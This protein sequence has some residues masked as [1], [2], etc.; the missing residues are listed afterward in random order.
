MVIAALVLVLG[1]GGTLH[2][3]CTLADIS[4]EE[5]EKRGVALASD[6]TAE[7]TELL[8]T[9]DIFSLYER[10]SRLV[11]S[12]SDVR[13]IVVLGPEGQVRASTFERGLPR[14]LREANTVAPDQRYA[15]RNIESDQGSILDVA[16]PILGGRAGSVRLGLSQEPLQERVDRQ[17]FT[18]LGLT[19]LVLGAGLLVAYVLATLLTRPLTRLAEAARAVGRGDLS[20]RVAVRGGDEVSRL[21]AAFNA[22]I[23]DLGRSR[24]EIEAFHRQVLRQNAELAALNAVAAA[25]GRSLDTNRVLA[26]ALNKVLEVMRLET[27]W[28][29]LRDGPSGLRMVAQRG[30]EA[31]DDG[32]SALPCPCTDVMRS[33][34]PATFAALAECPRLRGLEGG[35]AGLSCHVAVPLVAHD[36]PL[37][38][39]CVA[40]KDRE[41]FAEE[42]LR[43]LTSIGH[44]VGVAVENARLYHEVQR[45]EELHR[46]LLVK[47]I[48]AQEEERKRIARELHDESA[49]ALTALLMSLESLEEALPRRSSAVR[50]RLERTHSLTVAALA[51]TR[52]LIHDL[53][54]MALDELGLVPAIRSYAENRL[55]DPEVKVRLE[56]VGL[57]ER[58][59]PELETILFRIFQ[60]AINNCAKHA[61]AR[62]VVIHLEQQGDR[63]VGWVEDDGVGFDVDVVLEARTGDLALGLLGM[64]ER[65]NLVGGHLE[66]SSQPGQGTCIR[67]ELPQRI[68]AEPVG[69]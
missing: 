6:I 39:M 5:L 29:L 25:V 13:Y 34:G 55:T 35:A 17:T 57:R 30:L 7:A 49:Q 60:E 31:S 12:N 41:Q 48:G 21:A 46:Q 8:L 10:L 36:G 52:R 4:Q 54:P 59:A 56:T 51:E 47:V 69:R 19:G 53:R 16:M 42:D 43:L 38:V 50:R 62:N 27:G 37:G 66:I 61:K 32:A 22:M 14:G 63:V 28:V 33:G 58:L 24:R 26:D 67:V 23:E 18:L 40:A 64:Q 1:L 2:A 68:G 9:N 45:R 44:Y 3:R 11:A 15:V 20:R 65:A